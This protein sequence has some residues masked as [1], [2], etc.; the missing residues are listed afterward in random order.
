MASFIELDCP[1]G[2]RVPIPQATFESGGKFPIRLKFTPD[3]SQAWVSNAQSNTVAVFDAKTRQLLD[4][5]EVGEVPV[6]ILMTPDGGR[7]FVANT[8]ANQITVIDVP[9]RKVLRSFTT[10]TEPDGMAWAD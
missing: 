7:A 1:C 4:T 10:G 3:G 9:D 8:N 5:I 6:G 2:A